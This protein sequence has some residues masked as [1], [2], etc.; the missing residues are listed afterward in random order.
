[1]AGLRENAQKDP[2]LKDD[3]STEH[4]SA[5]TCPH[6]SISFILYYFILNINISDRLQKTVSEQKEEIKH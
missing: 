3:K 5:Y 6:G 4:I 2:K 1:M